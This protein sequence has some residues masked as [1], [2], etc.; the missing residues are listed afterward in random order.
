MKYAHLRILF[1]LAV[2]ALAALPL[3]LIVGY[4]AEALTLG[5]ESLAY[6]FFYSYRILHGEGGN[7][8]LA[9]GYP[10]SALQNLILILSGQ[11][12]SDAMS[13]R[14]AF[15]SFTNLTIAFNTSLLIASFTLSAI[16][17][18]VKWTDR[19][20]L[21]IV[22]L[23]PMYSTSGQGFRHSLWPDYYQ[24][25]VA[26][27]A[28]ALSLFQ[29]VWRHPDLRKSDVLALVAGIF[30][31]LATAN[32]ITV[33]V[34]GIPF[35]LLMV[36]KPGNDLI[37]DAK[38]SLL[39]ALGIGLGCALPVLSFYRFDFSAVS[40][41]FVMWLKFIR[42][43]GGDEGFYAQVKIYLIDNNLWLFFGLFALALA[44][45]SKD[46]LTRKKTLTNLIG[47]TSAVL[48]AT[49][50][51]SIIKRPA[52]TSIFEAAV[53]VGCLGAIL[54]TMLPISRTNSITTVA[55]GL[56]I[57][58][59]TVFL[60]PWNSHTAMILNSKHHAD[61]RWE[62]FNLVKEKAK[63]RP[64]VFFIPDNRYQA[65]DIF[66]TLLKGMAD[67]PSWHVS[68]KGRPTL[69]YFIPNLQYRSVYV[70][71]KEAIP[72]HNVIYIWNEVDGVPPVRSFFPALDYALKNK[73][74]EIKEIDL[75]TGHRFKMLE[76]E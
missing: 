35:L 33:G 8:V 37:I 15:N 41:A 54:L 23:G 40:E 20:L 27:A 73:V 28:L 60:F 9:Q 26:I 34:L 42:N 76:L 57:S 46:M 14:S 50:I 49:L 51:Y 71:N 52:G 22:G 61:L 6:R 5:N 75:E 2:S 30:V 10:L 43:P 65:Q 68:D 66:I 59:S 67:F 25:N 45:S 12:E 64:V 31:G 69:E 70:P 7:I 47:V 36:L 29:V 72:K 17:P 38:K 18:Q 44:L 62:A 74:Q 55:F 4:G 39:T 48:G 16:V 53:F 56:A 24:L 21:L 63:G 11:L 58:Y 1:W 32:K 19:I 3:L 13:L